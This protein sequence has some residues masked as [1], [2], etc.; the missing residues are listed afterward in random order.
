[1]ASGKWRPFCLG[2]N[3]LIILPEKYGCVWR[4]TSCDAI[5]YYI[6]QQRFFWI[7]QKYSVAY[8]LYVE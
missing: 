1:M 2:L 7:K 6:Y 5:V 4:P 3:V 8:M